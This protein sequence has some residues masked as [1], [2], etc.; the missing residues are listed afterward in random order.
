MNGVIT[1]INLSS[2]GT[3]YSYANIVITGDGTGGTGRAIISPI[4]GHGSNAPSELLS[5]ILCFYSSLENESNQGLL[6]DNQYRQ[7][8]LIKDV[9]TY[10]SS[11]KLNVLLG[12]GCFLVTAPTVTNVLED[13]VLVSGTKTFNVITST[14]T[15]ILLQSKDS[16]V[17]TVGNVLV[18]PSSEDV[19][20]ISDVIDP[21]INKFSGDM[22]IVDNRSAF[23]SSEQQ[24]V[25]FRSYIKF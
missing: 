3:G 14:S 13:M 24:A 25:I 12:S 17:P 4:G 5:D 1:N 8:G 6:V 10:D 21:S 9:E 22:L 18:N 7:Y 19:C 15:Q 23:T 11:S 16:S 2:Y 20:T